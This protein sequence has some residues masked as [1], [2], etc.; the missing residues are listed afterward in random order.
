MSRIIK[1]PSATISH[2]T[3]ETDATLRDLGALV[4][5]RNLYLVTKDTRAMSMSLA[6]IAEDVDRIGRVLGLAINFLCQYASQTPQGINGL[7][8]YLLK[9]SGLQ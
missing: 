2:D 8:D 3:S 6:V 1:L 9:E 4:A 7:M 5:A